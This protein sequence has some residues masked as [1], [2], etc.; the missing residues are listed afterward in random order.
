MSSATLK[1]FKETKPLVQSREF[2][3][4]W[5]PSSKAW[6]ESK[7]LW[8]SSITTQAWIQSTAP[9]TLLIPNWCKCERKRRRLCLGRVIETEKRKR[10]TGGLLLRIEETRARQWWWKTLK[11]GLNSKATATWKMLQA[12]TRESTLCSSA[13]TCCASNQL[14]WIR[15]CSCTT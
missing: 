14:N 15:R 6:K 4:K 10:A 8:T 3:K 12:I 9:K 13:V 7:V 5:Q 1:S 2:L 11:K